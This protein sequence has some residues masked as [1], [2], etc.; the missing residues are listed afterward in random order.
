M[1]PIAK[2]KGLSRRRML[3]VALAAVATPAWAAPPVHYQY[4]ADMPP[5]EIGKR[6]LTRGGP[7]AGYF[8]PVEV[9][10]PQGA[11]LSL[12]EEGQFIGPEKTS[13]LAGMQ[14]GHVYRLKVGR[15][16]NHP[17]QEVFPTIEVIDRLYPPPGQAARFPIP[18]ELTQEELEY[19][20]EG[21]YVTRVIYLEDPH[22]AMPVAEDEKHSQRVLDIGAQG[23]L[24][25]TA[26]EFG[27]PV[28]I[29]RMGSRVPT[30]SELTSEFMFDSPPLLRYDGK[31]RDVP[32]TAGLEKPQEAPPNNGRLTR[33]FKRLPES[34][35]RRR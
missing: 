27:R 32:R 14:I 7:L 31:P 12:A 29:L 5:G 34:E 26:D 17:G 30:E 3:A 20:M 1:F 21:R 22:N 4:N 33:N 18:V 10:A 2:Q 6:Q 19:A 11:L 23:D 9:K 28:A 24:L 15:I 8:Q 16:K 35:L 13:V 25:K